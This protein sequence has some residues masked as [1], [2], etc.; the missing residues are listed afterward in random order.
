MK[1]YKHYKVIAFYYRSIIPS[2]S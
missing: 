2:E 1:Q